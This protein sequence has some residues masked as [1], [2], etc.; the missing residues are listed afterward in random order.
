M[1]EVQRRAFR[2][3]PDQSES[4]WR[5]QGKGRA[6]SIEVR[7]R[8]K[9]LVVYFEG[10]Q[11]VSVSPGAA[12]HF[13]THLVDAVITPL[14]VDRRRILLQAD[15]AEFVCSHVNVSCA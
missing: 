11:A 9:A 10:V 5:V 4:I 14:D 12:K 6:D 2:K 8:E 1:R 7:Q 15:F 13:S 3:S